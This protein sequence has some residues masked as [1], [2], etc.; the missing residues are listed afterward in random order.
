MR[1]DGNTGN[2]E[3]SMK[4]ILSA[5]FSRLVVTGILIVLQVLFLV[6]LLIG[7]ADKF[8][9]IY[10]IFE[11]IGVIMFFVLVSEYEDPA[12][13][14]PWL[15]LI[16]LFVPLGGIIYLLF[17]RPHFTKGMKKEGYAVYGNL[18][19]VEHGNAVCEELKDPDMKSQSSYIYN[20]TDL[21]VH[22]NTSVRFEPL[23][24]DFWKDLL[25][26]L[27]NAKHFIFMEY[28]IIQEGTMWNAILEVL[29]EK[30]KEGVDVRLMYDDIGCI[31]LLPSDYDKTLASYG[32]KTKVF[33]RFSP[34]VSIF[35]NNRD[36]RKITVIDGYI[37]YTGGVNLADEYIN[38]VEVHGH[39]KDTAV[40]L[41]G[42]G[43]EN[44]TKLFMTTWEYTNELSDELTPYM[45]YVYH[46]GPFAGDG[47]YTQVY[48]DSPYDH[49]NVGEEVYMNI[50]NQAH[51]YVWIE[52]PYLIISYELMNAMCLAAKRGVD[53]RIITPHIADKWFVHIVTQ[54]HYGPLVEAG[55]KI[56][57]YTPGFI[58]SKLFVSDDRVAVVGTINLDYRSLVHH[59]EDGCWMCGTPAIKAI[60]DD[61]VKTLSV[62]TQETLEDIRKVPFFTRAV[63]SVIRFFAPLM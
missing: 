17:S 37:G 38:A 40:R 6:W 47:G 10:G 50:I 62:S 21:S 19:K 22:G 9:I 14:L 4:K 29:K 30:V 28:F 61:Y 48:G 13:K 44:L 59:L 23:G 46:P 5:I 26:D 15:T 63:R 55:V 45:P 25:I 7:F 31:K 2:M 8:S 36:H 51:D 27:K 57:E 52:T 12:F 41:E 53:V 24:E 18:K 56:Y 58:H 60:H 49:E 43:T 20:V 16:L 54:A 11:L 42:E 3:A 35:H 33:N 39:W 32:I 1:Y 34:A